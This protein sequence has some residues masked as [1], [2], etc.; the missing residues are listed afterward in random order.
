MVPGSP[1]QW[2]HISVMACQ[3][4]GNWT[5]CATDQLVRVNNRDNVKVCVITV[6]QRDSNAE[7]AS[8]ADTRRDDNV[9]ITLKDVTT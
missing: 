9:I 3:I 7:S 6:T 8:P 4:T 2:R 5:I 1:S